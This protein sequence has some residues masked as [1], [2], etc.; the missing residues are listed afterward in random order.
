MDADLAQPD[1][2]IGLVYADPV[3]ANNFPTLWYW[4][5]AGNVWV[6]GTDRVTVLSDRATV[7]EN[8]TLDA[9]VFQQK[10]RLDRTDVYG[11]GTNVLYVPRSFFRRRGTA[12]VNITIA[13]ADS[14][15]LPGWSEIV[16]PTAQRNWV[17]LDLNDNTVKVLSAVALPNPLD[18]ARYVLIGTWSGGTWSSVFAAVEVDD[19]GTAQ[20]IINEPMIV[21]WATQKLLIPAFRVRQD[22]L[23]D[24]Y[25]P[26]NGRFDEIDIS[27]S[28]TRTV[29]YNVQTNAIVNTASDAGPLSPTAGATVLA[30]SRGFRV[31]SQH[32]LAGDVPG[33]S[34][35]NVFVAGKTPSTARR[36]IATP[37]FPAITEPNLL[38]L[39]FTEGCYLNDP[40]NPWP[41]YGDDLPDYRPGARFFARVY[42]QTSTADYYAVPK[43]LFYKGDDATRAGVQLTLEKK[44]S[45]NA[46]IFS[47]SGIMP[48]GTDYRWYVLGADSVTPG[49]VLVATGAQFSVGYGPAFWIRRDDYPVEQNLSIR[50]RALEG[51]AAVS[52]PTPAILYP[53][54]MWTVTGR[55]QALYPDNICEVRT[56]AKPF[57]V[58]LASIN[59]ALLPVA[60]TSTGG[61]IRVT[62]DRLGATAEIAIR[63]YSDSASAFPARRYRRGLTV[64]KA[65]AT[66]AGTVR[67]ACI[68]DSLTNL[69][70]T[71]YLKNKLTAMGLTASFIGT[72]DNS[73]TPGEGRGGIDFAQYIYQ[74]TTYGTPLDAGAETAYLAGSEGARITK[75]PH[76]RVATGGDPAGYVHN[77]Y[78][79][80]MRFYLNRFAGLVAGWADPDFVVVSLGTNDVNHDGPPTSITNIAHG[81]DVMIHQIRTALPTAD[82]GIVFPTIPRTGAADF[83]WSAENKDAIRTILNF[84]STVM[85]DAKVFVLPVWAHLTQDADWPLTVA[86]TD[87]ATGA[88]VGDINDELHFGPT[89]KHQYAEVVASWIACRKAGV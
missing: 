22:G 48:A 86:S 47:V 79:W 88:V 19:P 74:K 17:Y 46:A 64:H 50:V 36:K 15:H 60:E 26:A 38:A 62:P 87:A 73:G 66:Q 56:Q 28:G 24:I 3:D 35:P 69:D 59:A 89:G 57:A 6:M 20:V 53:S 9:V 49:T 51:G 81:L 72:L 70:T 27:A 4:N 16:L 58:T 61:A 71:T 34:S 68:G 80:D 14:T 43:I 8:A 11:G 1:G 21:E 85:A 32:Q 12:Q 75:L 84:R 44:L 52:D 13:N 41:F 10:I 42:F 78:I 54:D 82:I 45:A 23:L 65:P 29:Y 31:T 5:D 63:R 77:G 30:R 76:L 67:V 55:D 40:F 18:I 39:G 25:V 7:L 83:K 33:G 2:R 37:S